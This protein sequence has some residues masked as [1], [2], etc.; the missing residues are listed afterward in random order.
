MSREKLIYDLHGLKAHYVDDALIW[1]RPEQNTGNK[2][3]ELPSPMVMRDIEPYKNMIDGRIITSRSEHKALLK[4]HNC[5]EVGNDTSH[6]KPK[7]VKYNFESR[8]KVLA[9]Q[10][11]DMSDKQ[12][13]SLITN[14]IKARKH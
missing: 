9:S 4:Q 2:M 14:E 10:L 13:K 5:V 3:S 11:A 8:K 12:V 6:M 7:P 1:L